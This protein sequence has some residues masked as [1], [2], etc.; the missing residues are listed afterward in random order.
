MDAD[1]GSKSNNKESQD[2]RT[3][4]NHSPYLHH[5]HLPT[6][7]LLCGGGGMGAFTWPLALPAPTLILGRNHGQVSLEET[8][9]GPS[10]RR[11][12]WEVGFAVR[13]LRETILDALD[14]KRPGCP[15]NTWDPTFPS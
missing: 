15:A 7:C 3:L 6:V 11:G 8:E 9:V 1:D 2:H 14:S 10:I 4:L 12:E 13:L 5:C